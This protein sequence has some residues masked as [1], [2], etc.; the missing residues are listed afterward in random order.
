MSRSLT[1]CWLLVVPLIQGTKHSFHVRTSKTIIG[2]VGVPFG[3]NDHG[4]VSLNLTK[5][6]LDPIDGDSNILS[7]VEA[8]FLLQ[9]FKNEAEFYQFMDVLQTNSSTCAFDYYLEAN[10]FRYDGDDYDDE[11]LPQDDDS[12]RDGSIQSAEHGIF[13][14]MKAKDRAIEYRFKK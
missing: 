2:P 9:R 11:S 3:F 13:L 10:D 8:G 1:A 6:S 14:S 5:F 7:K 12:F 4:L